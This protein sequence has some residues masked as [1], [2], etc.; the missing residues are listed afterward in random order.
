M[1]DGERFFK[2]A[3]FAFLVPVCVAYHLIPL[4]AVILRVV[5]H[6]DPPFPAQVS[7]FF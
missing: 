5:L 3:G 4:T 7:L 2:A 1:T 6:V